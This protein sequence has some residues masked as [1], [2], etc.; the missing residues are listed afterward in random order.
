MGHGTLRPTHQTQTP[1]FPSPPTHNTHPP[2]SPPPGCCCCCCCCFP[3][4]PPAGPGP[5]P[6]AASPA[7]LSPR[8]PPPP[9]AAAPRARGCWSSAGVGKGVVLV[10]RGLDDWVCVCRDGFVLVDW[11]WNWCGGLVCMRTHKEVTA[12]TDCWR[13]GGLGLAGWQV[14]GAVYVCTHRTDGDL[15]REIRPLLYTPTPSTHPASS[16]ASIASSGGGR[17]A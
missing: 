11:G 12:A 10:V 3:R 17:G 6:T 4:R 15:H 13:F 8:P 9:A 5:S 1:P 2:G 16:D 14:V 7:G